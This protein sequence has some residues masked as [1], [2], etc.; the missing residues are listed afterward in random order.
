MV[1]GHF[2]VKRSIV[3]FVPCNS[4][5]LSNFVRYANRCRETQQTLASLRL[6]LTCEKTTAL[7]DGRTR[8]I[9]R[10]SHSRRLSLELP[11]QPRFLG[12]ET[13]FPPSVKLNANDVL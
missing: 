10:S 4:D 6:Y 12:V 8:L 9:S 13:P 1:S 5:F 3:R 7:A 2:D 11:T